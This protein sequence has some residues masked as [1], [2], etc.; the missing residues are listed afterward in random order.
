MSPHPDW[1]KSVKSICERWPDH[2]WFSGHSYIIWPDE[3]IPPW[4]L[5]PSYHGWAFS[6]LAGGTSEQE[7]P[8]GHWFSGNHFWFRARV[9]ENSRRFKVGVADLLTHIEMAEPQFMLELAEE[10]KRGVLSPAAVCGHRVQRELLDPSVLEVRAARVG[11]GFSRARLQPFKRKVRQAQMFRKHPI[12]SRLLCVA[13]L[14]RWS[15]VRALASVHPNESNRMELRF[16]A[17]QRMAA[18]A[19]YLRVAQKHKEYRIRQTGL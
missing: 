12:L 1:F 19:E 4:C 15:L 14:I 17:I 6:V 8:D 18:Y 5:L 9:L 7:A 10:G 11:R 2:D 13:S 3:V 16:L